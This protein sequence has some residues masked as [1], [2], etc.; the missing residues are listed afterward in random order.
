M[1]NFKQSWEIK[2]NWQ[3]FFPFLGLILLGYSAYRL[4]NVIVGHINLFLVIILG[5]VLFSLLL[6]LI[7]F[8]F[9]KL[10]K[11]WIL[12]YRWEMIRVF[13]VFAITGTSS[14]FIGKPIMA[15]I[16]ITRDNLNAGAYWFLYILVGI[17]FYQMLLLFNGWLFGQFDFFWQFE[18]K[19]FGRFAPRK[20]KS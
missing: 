3:L 7:L 5:V 14:M 1:D 13:I 19:M 6:R 15:L 20:A 9:K 11:K 18:K 4:A 16:G 17:I 8:L 10:E 2:R 12:Q